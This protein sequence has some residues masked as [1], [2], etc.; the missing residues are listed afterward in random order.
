MLQVW[1]VKPHA[2]AKPLWTISRYSQRR[3]AV[4]VGTARDDAQEQGE[5]LEAPEAINP[6]GSIGDGTSIS[7]APGRPSSSDAAALKNRKHKAL[8]KTQDPLQ[9]ARQRVTKR[10]KIISNPQSSVLER[11]RNPKT[12]EFFTKEDAGAIH[13]LKRRSPK[14]HIVR[15]IGTGPLIRKHETV[16]PVRKFISVPNPNTLERRLLKLRASSTPIEHKIRKTNSDP[17]RETVKGGNVASEILSRRV[18][19]PG[20]RPGRDR[21]GERQQK[22]GKGL[23]QKHV[24]SKIP[25]V[26]YF[27][28][29][30]PGKEPV[31]TPTTKP[32]KDVALKSALPTASTNE[33]ASTPSQ[34]EIDTSLKNWH[35]QKVSLLERCAQIRATIL[36]KAI[37]VEGSY[38][39][40]TIKSLDALMGEITRHVQRHNNAF[41]IRSLVKVMNGFIR[42]ADRIVASEEPRGG[43]GG[44]LQELRVARSRLRQQTSRTLRL[45]R[46]LSS[47]Q[48]TSVEKFRAT[49]TQDESFAARNELIR[50]SFRFL[51]QLLDFWGTPQELAELQN[52]LEYRRDREQRLSGSLGNFDPSAFHDIVNSMGTSDD[53]FA[54]LPHEEKERPRSE[55]PPSREEIE[56]LIEQRIREM[57]PGSTSF[58]SSE[59]LVE[60]DPEDKTPKPKNPE[61]KESQVNSTPKTPDVKKQWDS[62]APYPNQSLYE[63]LFPT[64]NSPKPELLSEDDENIPR[65][66]LPKAPSAP[67]PSATM[68]PPPTDLF[69]IQRPKP[70]LD[71]DEATILILYNGSPSLSLQDFTSI[72]PPK[73]LNSKSWSSLTTPPAFAPSLVL[74]MRDDATLDRSRNNHYYLIFPSHLAARTYRDRAYRLY[75]LAKTHTPTSIESAMGPVRGQT[76]DGEDVHRAVKGFTLVPPSQN[77][78][79]HLMQKP[80][81]GR[82]RSLVARGGYAQIVGEGVGEQG[83]AF[84]ERKGGR[85]LMEFYGGVQPTRY[86]IDEAIGLDIRARGLGWKID[87]TDG[88]AAQRLESGKFE[89]DAEPGSEQEGNGNVWG[90]EKEAKERRDK[91]NPKWIVSFEDLIEARRFARAWHQRRMLWK[92]ESLHKGLEDKT[93][94]RTEV[95]W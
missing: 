40:A 89:F 37:G 48:T 45:L 30:V 57:L 4:A 32:K 29:S 47:E 8:P 23:V 69:P 18:R 84:G 41:V 5:Q 50:E 92:K 65:L 42:R 60:W 86:E 53:G 76:V 13:W 93:M 85:V 67:T 43:K 68:T 20:W 95:L 90:A 19:V 80:Y 87:R 83:V 49:G 17:K 66:P 56:A 74:P 79:L 55:A 35:K 52:F 15:K 31:S 16:S 71:P 73:P 61:A 7:N 63:E 72:L 77:F 28:R 34:R 59:P 25:R 21:R 62:S 82:V 46:V 39:I 81:P 12:G 64:D 9:L 51:H 33:P 24:T 11:S 2:I 54:E 78:A 88:F 6:Q 58:S 70:A 75:T 36:Q 91:G 10:R 1:R 44:M 14:G 3:G 38:K 94:V 27:T 26:K 22:E